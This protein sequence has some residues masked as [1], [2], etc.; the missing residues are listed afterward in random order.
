MN[1]CEEY[2]CLCESISIHRYSI[3]SFNELDAQ[4]LEEYIY[5]KL[6]IIKIQIPKIKS[7]IMNPYFI[8]WQDK[9]YKKN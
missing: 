2:T 3:E 6:N 4:G 9:Y 5:T 1:K 7:P 8:L